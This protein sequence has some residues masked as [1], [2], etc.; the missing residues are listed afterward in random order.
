MAGH[1]LVLNLLGGIALLVWATQMVRKGVMSAFGPRLRRVIAQATAGRVRACLAGL[2]VATALQSSSATGLP[3]V[4]FSE[5][6]HIALA[7]ALAVMLGADIGSTI[8]VQALS[9]KSGALA[10]ALLL[11][12]VG[13]VMI[14]KTSVW[15]HIGRIVIGLALMILSLGL[16]VGASQPLRDQGIFALVMQRLA[17]DPVL[18]LALGALFTW[19]AQSSVAVIL[20]VISLAT[21][22][23]L[24]PQLAIALVLGAN[25][26]SGLIPL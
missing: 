23:A 6:G 4:A 15:Q 7:P 2:G 10:P 21:A 8:V 25:V 18:A 19:V 22:G 24:S 26:G 17:D 1:T 9:L 14:A 20:F 12:G 13:L 16:I 5:R 3:V 11:V